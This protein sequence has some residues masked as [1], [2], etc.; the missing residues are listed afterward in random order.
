MSFDQSF[1]ADLVLESDRVRLRA[2]HPDDLEA[3]WSISQ[4]ESLFAWF[5]K[6]L[7]VRSDLESWM[8]DAFQHRATHFRFPFTVI[9]KKNGEVAGSTSLGTISFIDRRIEIGWTWYGNAFRGTGIN[10]HCKFLLLQYAFEQMGFM[11]V[12]IKTD[13]LNARSRAAIK[14]IGMT[15]E[16]ILRSHTQMPKGRRRDSAFS[17]MLLAEWPAAKE[18]L[19]TML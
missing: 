8:E 3:F 1:P 9:D 7:N 15:E 18:K 5:T 13:A 17:G 14:K 12:E 6:E 16:G 10:T 19:L 11:R 2:M 4:D